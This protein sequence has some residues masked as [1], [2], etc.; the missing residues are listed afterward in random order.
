MNKNNQQS[1]RLI[2]KGKR[3]RETAMKILI[4]DDSKII[5]DRLQKLVV[6]QLDKNDSITNLAELDNLLMDVYHMSPD[7]LILNTYSLRGTLIESIRAIKTI[8]P[9]TKIISLTEFYDETFETLLKNAGSDFFIDIS[10][11]IESV[12]DILNSFK[13]QSN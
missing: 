5:Y 13:N 2:S 11:G 8:K 1:D 4:V 7:V 12:P 6:R 9:L 3:Q 10:S